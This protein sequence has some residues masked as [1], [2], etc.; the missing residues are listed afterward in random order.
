MKAFAFSR[1]FHQKV[2]FMSFYNFSRRVM[3]STLGFCHP[4]NGF[5]WHFATFRKRS[6]MQIETSILVKMMDFHPFSSIFMKM[7]VFS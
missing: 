2:N 4:S 6:K 5:Y 1:D 7:E 3:K